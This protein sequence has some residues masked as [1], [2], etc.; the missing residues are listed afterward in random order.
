VKWKE[1]AAKIALTA[2][3]TAVAAATYNM[4]V[5]PCLGYVAQFCSAPPLVD[6]ER[7]ALTSLAKLPFTSFSLA[8]LLNL[9]KWGGVF[10]RSTKVFLIASLVR[11]AK[12]T[13][14]SWQTAAAELLRPPIVFETILPFVREWRE[15]PWEF[16]F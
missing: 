11:A 9:W 1:R 15:Q 14:T 10:F 7:C 16:S 8:G 2:A 4:R 12:I 6:L 5:L 3:S 13:L